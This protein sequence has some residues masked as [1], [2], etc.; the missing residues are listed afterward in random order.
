MALQEHILFP[1][2]Y[3]SK[4]HSAVSLHC[5]RCTFLGGIRCWGG[6]RDWRWIHIGGHCFLIKELSKTTSCRYFWHFFGEWVVVCTHIYSHC[7]GGVDLGGPL[8]KIPIRPLPA[9]PQ[10]HCP[11]LSRRGHCPHGDKVLWCGGG[12][13]PCPPPAPK[14]PP[15]VDSMWPV[16]VRGGGARSLTRQAAWSDNGLVWTTGGPNTAFFLYCR[17]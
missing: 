12:Q 2:K 6:H 4:H 13:S 10:N 7:G 9:D 11:G 17:Q 16:M 14:H 8:L 5:R 3:I 1:L 15:N